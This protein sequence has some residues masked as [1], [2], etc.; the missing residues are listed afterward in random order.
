[1]ETAVREVR[2]SPF[3]R[4]QRYSK[5]LRLG[6]TKVREEIIW[7]TSIWIRTR[8][9]RLRIRS[10]QSCYLCDRYVVLPMCP[11]RT[12]CAFGLTLYKTFRR[13]GLHLRAGLVQHGGVHAMEG[14]VGRGRTHAVCIKAKG[15]R[16]HGFAVPRVRHLPCDRLQNL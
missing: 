1:M 12:Q 9:H 11:G 14:T 6:C 16:E 4:S 13:H 10:A 2:C 15:R 5:F 3:E 7:D 8:C